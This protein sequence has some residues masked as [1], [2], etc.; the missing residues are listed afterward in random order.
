MN[1]KFKERVAAGFFFQVFFL[2]KRN[3]YTANAIIISLDKLHPV[4]RR[5]LSSNIQLLICAKGIDYQG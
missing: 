1:F 2:E 5:N 3:A 4:V